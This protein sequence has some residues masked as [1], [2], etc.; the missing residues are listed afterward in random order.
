M[1]TK[2]AKNAQPYERRQIVSYMGKAGLFSFGQKNYT[3]WKFMTFW[4]GGG[5]PAIAAEFVR[6]DE[7]DDDGFIRME[8]MREGEM[9][10]T[11]GLI[12]R[13]IPMSGLIM[14]KHL[15]KMKTFKPKDLVV[16]EKDTSSGPI[17]VG[18]IDLTKH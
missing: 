12:Y 3:I 16:Y 1:K 11:P 5:K 6:M 14:T 9:L 13:K 8:N 4:C 2:L 10:V 15:E 7:R 17:D 18:E